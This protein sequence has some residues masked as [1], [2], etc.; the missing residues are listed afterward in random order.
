MELIMSDWLDEQ[1]AFLEKIGQV[2][3]ST[4]A[5]APKPTTKKDEE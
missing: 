1:K 2:A 4:P 5:T 3:P